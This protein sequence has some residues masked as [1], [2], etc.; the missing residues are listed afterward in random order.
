MTEETKPIAKSLHT[1]KVIQQL[2]ADFQTR[3]GL[4]RG[5]ALQVALEVLGLAG[6][7]DPYGLA[8]K[9]MRLMK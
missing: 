9:A 5:E 3:Q 2:T 7:P 6:R 8:E 4:G 1:V